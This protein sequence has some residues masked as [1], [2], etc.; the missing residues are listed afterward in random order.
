MKITVLLFMLAL[1]VLILSFLYVNCKWSMINDTGYKTDSSLDVA[2]S[3]SDY[4]DENVIDLI[5]DCNSN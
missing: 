3:D 4:D 2:L 5:D 1:S